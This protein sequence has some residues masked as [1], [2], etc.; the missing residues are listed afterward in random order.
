MAMIPHGGGNET[1]YG[2]CGELESHKK[3]MECISAIIE[4]CA[5]ICEEE[6]E[7]NC[8][9]RIRSLIKKEV[10]DGDSKEGM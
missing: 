2:I 1:D 3:A 4:S 9:D 10:K 6:G 8:A 7:Y 5:K